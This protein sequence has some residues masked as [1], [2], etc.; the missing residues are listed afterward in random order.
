M[1]V[2][3]NELLQ[4]IRLGEDTSLEFKEIR[5]RGNRVVT[6]FGREARNEKCRRNTWR[7]CS[8]S[9]VRLV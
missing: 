5:F 3:P 8:S 2:G 4:R 9:E 7:G 1:F 6:I